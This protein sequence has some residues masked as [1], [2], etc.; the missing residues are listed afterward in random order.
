MR[1]HY[2]VNVCAGKVDMQSLRRQKITILQN[3]DGFESR[4]DADSLAVP[5]RYVSNSY[6]CQPY[7]VE[8]QSG[9]RAIL[10]TPGYPR[11]L[12]ETFKDEN[13]TGYSSLMWMQ[14]NSDDG[15]QL[16]VRFKDQQREC[17]FGI[18]IMD[19]FWPGSNMLV[20]PGPPDLK[21][22]VKVTGVEFLDWI[23]PE[24]TVTATLK[25]CSSAGSQIR[26]VPNG[27]G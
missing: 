3:F 19:R 12:I 26:D 1:R 11:L 8:S 17:R 20:V 22:E 6:G 2:E 27:V 13:I 5:I 14:D 24:V 25:C 10:Q 9:G 15:R 7:S 18:M 21:V 23:T 4:T 16:L